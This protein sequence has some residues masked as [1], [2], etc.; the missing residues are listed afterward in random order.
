MF[1]IVALV[2]AGAFYVGYGIY[3]FAESQYRRVWRIGLFLLGG[4]VL[5]YYEVHMQW[6]WLALGVAL[7]LAGTVQ[8]LLAAD[9][10]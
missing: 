10:K 7:V 6:Y 2:V 1:H 5:A 8:R 9:Q 3:C 4:A